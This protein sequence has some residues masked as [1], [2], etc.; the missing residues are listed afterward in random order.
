[1]APTHVLDAVAFLSRIVEVAASNP[2]Q[3]SVY[4]RW[5][6]V[7]T[8]RRVPWKDIASELAKALY[9]KDVFKQRE[10]RSVPIEQAGEGEFKYLVAA[11]MLMEGPR[12]AEI[13]FLPSQPGSLEQISH[14]LGIAEL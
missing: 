7:N 11:N 13:G 2:A 6:N 5:Y 9:K 4:Q 10:A 14:D 12:A 8:E 1:V 3:G